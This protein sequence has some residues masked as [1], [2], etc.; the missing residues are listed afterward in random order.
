MREHQLHKVNG[1]FMNTESNI[2]IEMFKFLISFLHLWM[3]L[4]ALGFCQYT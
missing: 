3:S 1:T 4:V 2:A